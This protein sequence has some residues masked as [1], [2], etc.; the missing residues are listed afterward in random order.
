M[1]S[2]SSCLCALLL[3]VHVSSAPAVFSVPGRVSSPSSTNSAAQSTA[4]VP[5]ASTEPNNPTWKITDPLDTDTEPI[6]GSLGASILG[7]DNKYIDLQNPD[8]L[9]PPT[10]DHGSVYV[11]LHASS[12]TN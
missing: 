5:F 3:A 4:T 9:A 10:T 12:S 1:L 7:P 2:V 8:I 6:R 11:T